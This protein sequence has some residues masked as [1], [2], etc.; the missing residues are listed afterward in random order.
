MYQN[1]INFGNSFLTISITLS[2]YRPCNFVR[3]H[4]HVIIILKSKC[5]I[6]FLQN[7]SEIVLLRERIYQL[8]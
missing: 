3:L 8:K 2:A 4:W 1:Q 7:L 6:F 5:M